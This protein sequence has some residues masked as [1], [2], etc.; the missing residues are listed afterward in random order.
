VSPTTTSTKGTGSAK[1]KVTGGSAKAGVGRKVARALD[2]EERAAL[3][4]QRDFLLASLRDLESEREAGDVDEA[5]YEALRDDYTARAARIIRVLEASKVK[6][7]AE[8]DG[9]ADRSRWRN[10]AVVAAV[11]AFVVVASLLVWQAAGDREGGESATGDIR[12]ST[13]DQ[14][15]RAL[16]LA[17]AGRYDEAVAVQDEILA[18]DPDNVEAM[19]YKG[20]FQFRAGDVAGVVTLT[21]AAT[22][23]PQYPDAH[24][25]LAVSFAQLSC[26]DSAQAELDRLDQLDPP[27]EITQLVAG[28]RDDIP[29]ID[30][31]ACP[32][33]SAG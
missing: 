9:A 17:A 31:T 12:Q 13:Q 21:E 24:A 18:G 23:D 6:V 20:W 15:N 11:G 25:L 7:A 27:Q 28:L 3:E 33:P 26:P 2:A 32:I 19:T 16:S 4:D 30:G 29:S 5:D 8:P 22:L 1:G 14:L 10:R